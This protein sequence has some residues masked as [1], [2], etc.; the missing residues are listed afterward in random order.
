[1]HRLVISF[2]LALFLYLLLF[3]VYAYDLHTK[4]RIIQPPE[5][6][7]IS[8]ASLRIL[9]APP[10]KSTSVQ[11]RVVQ[12]LST[13][14]SIPTPSTKHI[15]HHPKKLRSLK[16]L[17]RHAKKRTKHL[18]KKLHKNKKQ[19]KSRTKPHKKRVHP[20][21]L[22]SLEKLFAKHSTPKPLVHSEP[23]ANIRKLY[24]DEYESFTKNQKRFIRDNLDKIAAITQKYLYVRGYP[25]IAAR[26]KQEGV[27]I[28]EFYLHPNGDISGL[29]IIQS[30][31]Y[32]ALDKNSLETVRDAYKDYPWPKETTKIRILIH[33][34]IIY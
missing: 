13:P 2:F 29:R 27:N 14:K 34:S 5:R 24:H 10:K 7:R 11:K 30:S 32:E 28:V 20:Q 12:S 33:Y 19:T 1:M 9:Q 3:L 8:L 22:P 23:P 18:S 16:V 21:A 17:A 15:F 4:P 25:Y 26:T 31:G 6:H